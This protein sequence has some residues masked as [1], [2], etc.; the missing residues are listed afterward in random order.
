MRKVIV[1]EN[2]GKYAKK[3]NN[4]DKEQDLEFKIY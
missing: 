1:S 2:H 4:M 3:N